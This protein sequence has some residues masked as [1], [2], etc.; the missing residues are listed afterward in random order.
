MIER[1]LK[2][3]AEKYKET[4]TINIIVIDKDT[5]YPE[6]YT[7]NTLFDKVEKYFKVTKKDIVS[8]TRLSDVV[9]ARKV[10]C[11]IAYYEFKMTYAE[12]GQILNRK[13]T[14][15]MYSNESMHSLIKR[16]KN[17]FKRYKEVEVLEKIKKEIING[18][19]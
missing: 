14:T 17:G 8:K 3:I 4:H 6:N 5:S 2:S 9:A 18:I 13:H 16:Q 11:W 19:N 7:I 10:I 12:I 15:I 1:D